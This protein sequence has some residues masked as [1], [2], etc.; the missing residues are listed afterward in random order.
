[1]L[2]MGGFLFDQTNVVR[3]LHEIEK[4]SKNTVKM[5]DMVASLLD[6]VVSEEVDHGVEEVDHDDEDQPEPWR[7]APQVV[8]AAAHC[9][10]NTREGRVISGI[11]RNVHN[12]KVLKYYILV[13]SVHC[14]ENTEEDIWS[15][16]GT[17]TGNTGEE[18]VSG[19]T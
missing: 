12:I 16:E 3:R 4:K 19:I 5:M 10:G 15:L 13:Q 2:L 9:P 18:M 11:S 6:V 7:L 8:A 1:M 14:P 17:S